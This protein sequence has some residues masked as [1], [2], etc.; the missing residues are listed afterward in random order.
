MLYK[1]LASS[2]TA[3]KPSVIIGT[4]GLTSVVFNFRIKVGTSFLII[5]V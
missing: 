3:V 1:S 4:I 2:A 5:N